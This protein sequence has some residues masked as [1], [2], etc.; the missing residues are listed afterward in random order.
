[1]KHILFGID[2]G[3]KL[4]GN[5]VIAI[6]HINKIYFLEVEKNVDADEFV[7]NAANHFKPDIIFLDAPLTLPGIY[8]G[9]KKCSDYHFREAD[10][11]LNAMSPMFLGGLTARAMQLKA[12]LE[13][14]IKTKVFETYPRAQAKNYSLEEF[15]YK[16]TKQDLIICR[17]RLKEKLNTN[18]FID[19]QDIT[20]W[21]HLDAM[22]ALFGAMRFVTGQ[23]LP[24]GNAREGLIYV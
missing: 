15:G 24:Y 4:S 20:T 23:A 19:C 21:H 3:S 12:N 18:L 10:R 22:L 16:K 17:N 1:M 6:L 13:E 14:Q 5:T 9:I 7:L 8:T 11:A 2:Y